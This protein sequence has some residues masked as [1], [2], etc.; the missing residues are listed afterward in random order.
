MI[1]LAKLYKDEELLA[2]RVT[3][4]NAAYINALR[5][6]MSSRVPTMAIDSVEF[7][8]NSSI[9]YDEVIAHRLG[10]IPLKTDLKSYNL[11][12]TEWKEPTG[13]PRV[14]VQLTL[15]V[16]KVKQETIVRAKDFETK[17]KKIIPVHDQ[18]PIVKLLEGQDLQLIA[19]ARLGLGE[20]H[21]KWCPAHV[22]HR[23]YPHIKIKKQPKNPETIA[24]A[25]P[26]VFE[27]KAKKLALKK[28]AAYRLPD[29]ELG[30]EGIE[31]TYKDDD[32]ILTIES[33]GQLD[34][35]TIVTEALKAYD[36]QLDEFVK[37]SKKVK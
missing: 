23:H 19:T 31:V 18:M 14:E 10:L 25:Y 13:D 7:K 15:K 26:E 3:G 34:P 1:K 30:I 20:D 37:L 5:R 36:D 8:T 11:P 22:W 28:D 4:V 32:Y 16:P 17:D 35:K 2:L 12:K 33:W 21:V 29:V 24:E 6:Y 27:I 9:L